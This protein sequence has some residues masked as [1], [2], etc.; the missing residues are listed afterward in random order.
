MEGATLLHNST[1]MFAT[2][3]NLDLSH[4]TM[5]LLFVGRQE[6]YI[7]VPCIDTKNIVWK[8][9][10]ISQRDKLLWNRREVRRL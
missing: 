2:D 1:L 5:G 10:P 3:S 8:T 6:H 7:F 4:Q 9:T